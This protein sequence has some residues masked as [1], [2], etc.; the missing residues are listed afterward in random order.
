M[1]SICSSD[2]GLSYA[3]VRPG[4]WRLLCWA[5]VAL[6]IC[7]CALPVASANSGQ[8]LWLQSHQLPEGDAVSGDLFGSAVAL[9]GNMAL[10][11]APAHGHL[12][13]GA[14]AA[15]LFDTTTG[16]QL[17]EILATD[18]VPFDQYAGDKFGFGV[19]LS[20]NQALVSAPDDD[21]YGPGAGAIYAYDLNPFVSTPAQNL[22][23]DDIV[24]GRI[25]GLLNR[26]QW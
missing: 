22:S 15:Y 7:P 8:F 4:G 12:G 5:V 21:E 18:E 6:L 3:P 25:T 13:S 9:D 2:A 26:D 20:G 14:G 1:F 11:G 24:G 16:N 10:V 23:A 19:A 17:H